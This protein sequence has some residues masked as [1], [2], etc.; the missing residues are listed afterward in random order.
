MEPTSEKHPTLSQIHTEDHIDYRS[1]IVFL[2][3]MISRYN[4]D[5]Q[6]QND[7][8]LQ[9]SRGDFDAGFVI[10]DFCSKMMVES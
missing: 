5:V 2:L 1:T 8:E 7:L 4:L 9:T 10:H 6:F 3:E